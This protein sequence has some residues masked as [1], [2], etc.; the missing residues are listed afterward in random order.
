[1]RPSDA[2]ADPLPVDLAGL[3]LA[4]PVVL[5]AGTAGYV[6]EMAG[7]MD[8]AS[9]GAVVTKSITGE[10]REGNET[11]RVAELPA[12]MLNAIGLANVGADRFA[13]EHGPR[14]GTAGTVVIGSIAGHSV[15]EFRRVAR[16]FEAIDAIPA[17]EVNVS[18]PN[19]EQGTAFGDSPK[20]LGELIGAV[21]AVLTRTKLIAKLPP[22]CAATADAPGG[23]LPLARAA[24]DAGADALTIA[25]T[26]PAMAIDVETRRPR[27]AN[28]TGGLSG[29]AVHPIAVRL[30][31]NVYT[32]LAR[33]RGVPIIGAGGVMGWRDAAEMILAGASAVEVGTAL[34]ADPRAP[35]R[36]LRGLRKW[37]R[38]QGVASIGELVG[39]VETGRS[40]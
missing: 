6:D 21:R 30:I 34:F 12:G 27:L 31:H 9:V 1:V 38:A 25:N 7:A 18:C 40:P 29:P 11:W 20:A 28:V 19:V 13:A 14:V 26:V 2:P 24:V 32:G 15:D 17:V 4:N 35:Q 22:A 33:E 39:A 3:H 37:V 8:L 10:P 36:I 23:I 16:M 5:A